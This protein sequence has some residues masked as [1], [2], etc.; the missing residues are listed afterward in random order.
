MAERQS[1]EA[2]TRETT[3]R[4]KQWKPAR[5]LDVPPAPEGYKYRWVRRELAG[6]DDAKNVMGR[7]RQYYEP[8]TR[9]ELDASGFGMVQTIEDSRHGNIVI[10]GDLML[11]KVPTEIVEQRSQY[12]DRK[13]RALEVSVRQERQSAPRMPGASET[14]IDRSESDVSRGKGRFGS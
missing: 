13:N 14:W 1:R 10:V 7:L 5:D 6:N 12:Y 11:M 9:E 2:Q 4:A 8:V 3:A